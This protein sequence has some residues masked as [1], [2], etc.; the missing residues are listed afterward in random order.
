MIRKC[1]VC[2][3]DFIPAELCVLSAIARDQTLI[4]HQVELESHNAELKDSVLTGLAS[5]F[6]KK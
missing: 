5:S 3:Q 2:Y 1:S 4:S 6:V